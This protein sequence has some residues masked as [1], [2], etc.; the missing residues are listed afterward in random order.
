MDA[1]LTAITAAPLT[2]R[3]A[4]PAVRFPMLVRCPSCTPANCAAACVNF[5]PAGPRPALTAWPAFC[6]VF[7][8]EPG[9]YRG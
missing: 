5:S 7:P 4:L 9:T 8:A 1:L 2:R 3:A 6:L